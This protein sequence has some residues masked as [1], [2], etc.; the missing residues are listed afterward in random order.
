MEQPLW[1]AAALICA[2]CAGPR[3]GQSL[4]SSSWAAD[5][6]AARAAVAD[7]HLD[8]AE[9]RLDAALKETDSFPA[10]DSRR[11]E[12]LDALAGVY[13][14]QGRMSDAEKT[15]HSAL[16]ACSSASADPH[17]TIQTLRELALLYQSQGRYED[18]LSLYEKA[19]RVAKRIDGPVS[20][21]T[22][23]RLEDLALLQQSFSK[24]AEAE[25]LYRRAISIRGRLLR[26]GA[27][28]ASLRN[29]ASFLKG[30]RRF[31]ESEVYYKR[32][33]AA[34]ERHST[35][36]REALAE[37]LDGYADLLRMLKRGPEAAALEARSRALSCPPT[38]G[39]R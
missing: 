22:A 14:M 24:D 26:D 25:A 6:T 10:A 1:L 21:S 3:S 4:A 20:R 12:S 18:A 11:V 33:L 27:Y 35:G 13:S 36:D 17:S 32:A 34:A 19:A 8:A 38:V 5:M 9:S 29:F 28:A 15:Y 31:A 37:T 23:E 39:S 30:A 2:G 16:A 7:G